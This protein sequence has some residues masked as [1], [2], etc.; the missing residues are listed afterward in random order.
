MRNRIKDAVCIVV[1]VVGLI[2]IYDQIQ[3]GN[4]APWLKARMTKA[5]ATTLVKDYEV[6]DL[7]WLMSMSNTGPIGGTGLVAY[8]FGLNGS[9]VVG[10]LKPGQYTAI[11]QSAVTR[12]TA[13]YPQ[14]TETMG[15]VEPGSK[16]IHVEAIL[17][18][19]GSSRE[20]VAYLVKSDYIRGEDAYKKYLE[21]EPNRK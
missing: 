13:Y 17:S 1:I 12:G 18:H 20:V 4:V 16:M 7:G 14:V 9:A 6:V 8:T 5:E 19:V 15:G 3:R 11:A 10:V 21:E 2:V